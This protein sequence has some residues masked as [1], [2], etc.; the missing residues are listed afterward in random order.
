MNLLLVVGYNFKEWYQL[1]LP[2]TAVHVQHHHA[3]LYE[4]VAASALYLT[5]F[6]QLV[7]QLS[8]NRGLILT[9]P[10]KT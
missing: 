1:F 7:S 6:S 5:S 10:L 4:N 2:S 3:G 9:S 8:E